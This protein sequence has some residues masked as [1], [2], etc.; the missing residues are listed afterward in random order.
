MDAVTLTVKS[1]KQRIVEMLQALTTAHVLRIMQQLD[2]RADEAAELVYMIAFD[3]LC[4]R[5]GWQKAEEYSDEI[6][7]GGVK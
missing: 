3:V 6:M 2:K 5:I 1:N 7:R 4:E